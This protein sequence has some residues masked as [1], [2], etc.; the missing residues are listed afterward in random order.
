MKDY[1]I[2]PDGNKTHAFVVGGN[3]THA[4]NREQSQG[5]RPKTRWSGTLLTIPNPTH[6]AAEEWKER[7]GTNALTPETTTPPPEK[8]NRP[9][10]IVFVNASLFYLSDG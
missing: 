4:L 6:F 7:I 9:N 10:E 8:A 5:A 1:R 2:E 3:G